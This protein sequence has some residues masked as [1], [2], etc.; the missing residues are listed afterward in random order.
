MEN[1]F[2]IKNTCSNQKRIHKGTWKMPGS[3]QSNQTDH[4]LVSRRHGSSILDVKT[5][6]GPI[7][8]S[9]HY[10]VKVEIKDRLA[11][12]DNNKSYKRKNGK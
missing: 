7:C 2:I 6:R 9:D 11:T 10:L 8:D 1:N 4:L 5:A 12:I 3:E